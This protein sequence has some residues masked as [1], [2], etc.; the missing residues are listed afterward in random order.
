MAAA[1]ELI[2]AA[3][4][5]GTSGGGE[6]VCRESD[7]LYPL[8][9]SSIFFSNKIEKAVC[10]H[11]SLLPFCLFLT[12]DNRVIGREHHTARE[13]EPREVDSNLSCIKLEKLIKNLALAPPPS[14]PV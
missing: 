6:G 4:T 9:V 8:A 1:Y 14:E 13:P 3:S 10:F 5:R 12:P 7:G 11:H 2:Q